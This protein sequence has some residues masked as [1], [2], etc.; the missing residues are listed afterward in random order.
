[1]DGNFNNMGM[2]GMSGGNNMG[3]GGGGGGPKK[4]VHVKVS[5]NQDIMDSCLWVIF[6]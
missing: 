4:A 2:M 3:G 6:S 5:N 1:M